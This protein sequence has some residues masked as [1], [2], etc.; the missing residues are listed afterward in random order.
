MSVAN[1]C[2]ASSISSVKEGDLYPGISI[3]FTGFDTVN[4]PTRSDKI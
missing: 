3:T 2:D 4:S 1:W